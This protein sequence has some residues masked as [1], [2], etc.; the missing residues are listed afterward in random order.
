MVVLN[1]KLKRFHA[2]L[3]F[4]CR[5][6]TLL[7]LTVLTSNYWM[8]GVFLQHV[9]RAA[10]TLGV[11]GFQFFSTVRTP[12]LGVTLHP[13]RLLSPV[14]HT[15]P[16]ESTMYFNLHII[17]IIIIIIIL[18]LVEGS[19]D[20][21]VWGGWKTLQVC[22]QAPLTTMWDNVRSLMEVGHMTEVGFA[23]RLPLTTSSSRRQLKLVFPRR[24]ST[25]SFKHV[26][27]ARSADP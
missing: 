19:E 15:K 3:Y 5:R 21:I 13:L 4:S 18:L 8:I 24:P 10:W 25:G 9:R 6:D 12:Y 20:R 11:W 2:A 17:I 27:K 23:R 7:W 26:R 1:Q 16:A 14:R 22:I